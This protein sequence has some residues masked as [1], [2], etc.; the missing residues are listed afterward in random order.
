MT[1]FSKLLGY[2]DESFKPWHDAITMRG[3]KVL[4]VEG[5]ID[6]RYF[7]RLKSPEFGSQALKEDI[8]IFSYNGADNL[9]NESI[10]KLV[11]D[12]SEKCVV[13]CDLDALPQVEKTIKLLS[14]EEGREFLVI[15]KGDARGCIEDYVPKHIH[16]TVYAENTHL[17]AKLMGPS[18]EARSAKSEMKKKICEHLLAKGDSKTDFSDFIGLSK[19]LNKMFS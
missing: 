7:E 9:K 2:S 16:D 19:R 13:T 5:D 11:I 15:G 1:P 17:V 18:S 6:K 4:L 10:L 8:Q 14:I 3:R 12:L